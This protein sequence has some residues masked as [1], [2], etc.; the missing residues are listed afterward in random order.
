MHPSKQERSRET[1][2][3]I[4]KATARILRQESFDDITVRRIVEEAETSI[5][6]FYARFRDKDAL[7]SILYAQ[8]EEQL[9]SRLLRLS[10]RVGRASTLDELTDLTADHFVALYGEN[11]NLSRA[12]FEYATRDPD[13]V[14]SKALSAQRLQQYGFLIDALASFK[15]RITHGD[16]TRAVE[17][18]LYFLTV[19][20]RNRLCYP[21]GPQSRTLKISKT[22]LKS[23]LS[24]LLLGYLTA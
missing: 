24:R 7:L 15:N 5:G 4:L 11:P 9:E 8:S 20:C 16:P 19:A 21:F 18:G 23:E 2:D 10:K 12:L 22:E 14:G 3:R 1:Q 13:S 17:L 6:S